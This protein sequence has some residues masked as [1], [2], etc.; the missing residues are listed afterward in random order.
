MAMGRSAATP[1]DQRFGDALGESIGVGP[2]ELSCADHSG[3]DQFVARPTLTLLAKLRF[4]FRSAELASLA[5]DL[6][7]K[8]LR[9][10]RAFG[11]RLNLTRELS[12]RLV[13]VLRVEIGHAFRSVIG[14]ERFSD[15]A[16][17][18]ADHVTGREVQHRRVIALA[19]EIDQMKRAVNV[20]R[21]RL[22]QIGIEISQAGAVDYQIEI[23]FQPCEDIG[24][25]SQTRLS[26]VA[27]DDFY[28]F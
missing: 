15:A 25:Y 23:E 8:S 2:A 14:Y 28:F 22:A 5:Q 18:I 9:D 7:T 11:A 10:Q 20:D 19:Q 1:G 27:L 13:F 12:Q 16:V 4:E 17:A 26:D 6:L 24:F 21:Q 3:L